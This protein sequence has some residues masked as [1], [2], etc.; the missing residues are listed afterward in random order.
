MPLLPDETS[1]AVCD[2][3]F[4]VRLLSQMFSPVPA[5]KRWMIE[6]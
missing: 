4:Q 3:E 5:Q 6:G 1:F 2:H